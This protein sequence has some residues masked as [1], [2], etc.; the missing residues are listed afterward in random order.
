MER[1]S[2]I[3]GQFLPHSKC[4][5]HI[6]DRG[7][8]F[9]DGIYEVILLKNNKLIDLDWHLDR[10]YRSLEGFSIKISQDRN[11]FEKMILELF[12]K[13]NLSEGSVYL[14]ITRGVAARWQGFP[15]EST[16]TIVATVSPLRT[17]AVM[18]GLS[19][20][21]HEDI[22]WQRCDI[23]SVSL[24][25]SSIIKQKSL[26]QG[27]NDAILIRDGFITEATFA[28]VFI[29][30][31]DETLITRNAD[32]FVLCGITKERLVQLAKDNGIKVV[33]RKFDKQE[34]FAASEVFLT[35]TTLLVRPISKIDGQMIGDGKTGKIS[36][37]LL[38]LYQNFIINS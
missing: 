2:F 32:N 11:Y 6:E 35:S 19:V 3:N 38:N 31:K 18:D 17:N 12:A 15:E 21:T 13:N 29:V 34:L 33:E 14:Q 7:F 22:R 1:I 5:V 9:A 24:I 30:D 27:C 16:P 4:F 28:N 20:I 36:Q 37:K 25:A 23:K 10:L 8:Q 26:D